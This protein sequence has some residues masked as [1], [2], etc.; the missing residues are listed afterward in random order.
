MQHKL[1]RY[2]RRHF[3]P[4]VQNYYLKIGSCTHIRTLERYA[5][6]A[7]STNIDQKLMPIVDLEEHTSAMF[8]YNNQHIILSPTWHQTGKPACVLGALTFV[9]TRDMTPTL[10]FAMIGVGFGYF[11]IDTTKTEMVHDFLLIRDYVQRHDR[12]K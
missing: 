10:F 5:E 9:V 8:A 3:L 6:L 11:R 12:H 1:M 2:A 4:V 7:S